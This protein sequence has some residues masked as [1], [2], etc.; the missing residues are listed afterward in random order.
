[1]DF[2]INDQ[3]IEI[4]DG[5]NKFKEL[6]QWVEQELLQKDGKVLT[7]IKVNGTEIDEQTEQEIKEAPLS[8][9]D[10][11]EV[12]AE[13]PQNLV[14]QGLMDADA[15][16]P[17]ILSNLDVCIEKVQNQEQEQAVESF[18]KV[19]DGLSWFSTI[20]SGAASVFQEKIVAMQLDTHEFVM[21]SSRLNEILN[22]ILDAYNSQ[23]NVAFADLLEFEL[24]ETLESLRDCVKDFRDKLST[25]Q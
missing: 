7:Q 6:I 14:L 1:M 8:S 2:S 16:L 21:N 15:M 23:D 9:I 20:Y 24:K 4:K 5:L 13:T 10:S 12:Q 17:E 19:T 25:V 3:K 11:V 18:V 22:D